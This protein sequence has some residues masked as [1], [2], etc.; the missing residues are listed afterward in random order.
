MVFDEVFFHSLA[1]KHM[2]LTMNP[3]DE[4]LIV[5]RRAHLHLNV[6]YCIAPHLERCARHR[7][8]SRRAPK[9]ACLQL[10]VIF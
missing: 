1:V 6:I 10:V 3:I 8:G 5:G 2:E 4:D 9:N 7:D